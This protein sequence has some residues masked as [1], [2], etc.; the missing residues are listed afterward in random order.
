MSYADDLKAPYLEARDRLRALAAGRSPEA[1]NRKPDAT[2]WSAAE[3]VV[4]LNKIAKG[5]LPALEAAVAADGPRGA[6]PFRYGWLARKFVDALR[7]GSRAIPTAPAM[8]P[9]GSEGEASDIDVARALGR[10]EADTER[11]L[12]VIDR[13]GGLDLAAIRVRS[14]FMTLLKLPVGAF[15]EALGVHGVRHVAQAER[16]VEATRG[17]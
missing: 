11:Y 10:F 2:A 9:P 6:P 3:C 4:H 15:L 8:K 5:Y 17:R 16:A 7:P 13:A 12:A 14:P 1:L